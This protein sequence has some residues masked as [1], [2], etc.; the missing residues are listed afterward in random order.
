MVGK[1]RIK[2]P[3]AFIILCMFFVQIADP[4]I[5]GSAADGIY[6]YGDT[7]RGNVIT[8]EDKDRGNDRWSAD[9]S[10]VLEEGTLWWVQNHNPLQLTS[11]SF[12]SGNRE[13]LNIPGE[14]SESPLS[15]TSSE[16]TE[17]VYYRTVGMRFTIE[18]IS[19]G[20]ENV[21][22]LGM[23][24]NS[25]V[26]DDP[27]VRFVDVF[28]DGVSGDVRN[29]TSKLLAAGATAGG[30]R[31]VCNETMVNRDIT[32]GSGVIEGHYHIGNFLKRDEKHSITDD[33][34]VGRLIKL[35]CGSDTLPMGEW[36]IYA[37]HIIEIMTA[38]REKLPD[39]R[40][41]LSNRRERLVSDGSGNPVPDVCTTLVD[42]LLAAGWASVTRD[43]YLPALFNRY[44]E[45]TGE[46]L[47]RT[48]TLV[49]YYIYGTD[50]QAGLAGSRRITD[51][52]AGGSAVLLYESEEGK[53]HENLRLALNAS[54]FSNGAGGVYDAYDGI[55]VFSGNHEKAYAPEG[56]EE[57]VHAYRTR[58]ALS[59]T[60]DRPCVTPLD[61]VSESVPAGVTA[62]YVCIWAP[63][64]PAVR[65]T[66]MYVTG[67]DKKPVLVRDAGL[68]NIASSGVVSLMAPGG[69]INGSDTQAMLCDPART[70]DGA[71]Y[72][73]TNGRIRC[74]Y[75]TDRW[76]ILRD[77][78]V[79]A[80][81]S[82]GSANRTIT[83]LLLTGEET[84]GRRFGVMGEGTGGNAVFDYDRH[85]TDV[86]FFVPV[87]KTQPSVTVR[88]LYVRYVPADGEARIIKDIG[89]IVIPSAQNYVYVHEP[90]EHVT[91]NGKNYEP[92]TLRE[93]IQRP[94]LGVI[95]T[96]ADK[97]PRSYGTVV[98]Q[99]GYSNVQLGLRPDGKV[100]F[101]V[102]A[103]ARDAMLFIP[104]EEKE[105]VTLGR[106]VNIYYIKGAKEG[107]YKVLAT[108]KRTVPAEAFEAAYGNGLSGYDLAVRT[109]VTEVAT[110]VHWKALSEPG[111][112]DYAYTVV[113]NEKQGV[114]L[115]DLRYPGPRDEEEWKTELFSREIF[116]DCVSIGIMLSKGAG[117]YEVFVPC[118]IRTGNNPVVIYAFDAS[119]GR[120]LKNDP[121]STTY[122]SGAEG[123]IDVSWCE[124]MTFGEKTYVMVGES[125]EEEKIY[126]FGTVS[127]AIRDII[128]GI[129]PTMQTSSPYIVNPVCRLF[130]GV[131]G[132]KGEDG[133]RTRNVYLN[134]S[135]LGIPSGNT[136]AV[137]VPFRTSS[138]VNVYLLT[139]DKTHISPK[140]AAVV[141]E[142]HHVSRSY[143]SVESSVL[144]QKDNETAGEGGWFRFEVPDEI[145]D[146]N[147]ISY[148]IADDDPVAIHHDSCCDGVLQRVG[149]CGVLCPLCKGTGLMSVKGR[150]GASGAKEK[151]T[152]CDGSG[153]YV[154]AMNYDELSYA[155]AL[156]R[157]VTEVKYCCGTCLGTGR[158]PG[159]DMHS[160]EKKNCPEC[161]RSG[162]G[163][164]KICPACGG[165]KKIQY[166]DWESRTFMNGDG[167]YGTQVVPV[168]K[169]R[170]CAFCD[171]SGGYTCKTC[172]GSGL[173]DADLCERCQVVRFFEKSGS[174]YGSV[175]SYGS[176]YTVRNRGICENC[177]GKGFS[178]CP[179]CK[180]SGWL[181][182]QDETG[183]SVPCTACGGVRYRKEAE[184]G[185]SG[186]TLYLIT[187]AHYEYRKGSGEIKC[188]CT[189]KSYITDPA[190]GDGA[191][192][193]GSWSGYY[194]DSGDYVETRENTGFMCGG[195]YC[196]ECDTYIFSAGFPSGGTLVFGKDPEGRYALTVYNSVPQSSYD[197][198]VICDNAYR[199]VRV[200]EEPYG[201]VENHSECGRSLLYTPASYDMAVADTEN[202]TFVGRK[203]E[204]PVPTAGGGMNIGFEVYIPNDSGNKATDVYILY[205]EWK[206]D[207]M[208]GPEERI[209][210]PD[211]YERQPDI[212][213]TD[214]DTDCCEISLIAG[215]NTV[216]YDASLSIPSGRNVRLKA[217]GKEYLY[218]IR[219]VNITGMA[220]IPVT[221]RYPYAFYGSAGEARL[222]E[223]PKETGY[224]ERTVTV[225]R[226]YAYWSIEKFAVWSIDEAWAYCNALSE[227]DAG[228]V[229]ITAAAS[230][231]SK[232]GFTALR[233]GPVQ[234]RLVGC[235]QGENLVITV[236]GLYK[237]IYRNG[238]APGVPELDEGYAER[239]AYEA[240]PDIKALND[241][242]IFEGTEVIG[243]SQSGFS[244]PQ[245][246]GPPASYADVA[247]RPKDGGTVT[248]FSADRKIPVLKKNG[249]Y[250][251]YAAT[252]NYRLMPGSVGSCDETKYRSVKNPAPV[253]VQTPV[254]VKGE[255]SM[256]TGADNNIGYV[257]REGADTTQIWAVLGEERSY[258]GYDIN[259]AA[260]TFCT[261]DLY[262]K[263]TNRA[264]ESHPHLPYPGY[265]VR[266]FD[267]DIYK[268]EGEELPYNRISFDI[269]VVIDRSPGIGKASWEPDHTEN[270]AD[271]IVEAGEWISI[272]ADTTV[273]FIVPLDTPEGRHRITFAS[274]ATNKE[275]PGEPLSSAMQTANTY[276]LSHAAYDRLFF[277]V[278]GRVWGLKAEIPELPLFSTERNETHGPEIIGVGKKSAAGLLLDDP[279]QKNFPAGEKENAVPGVTV[280]FTLISSGVKAGR[281]IIKNLGSAQETGM[282]LK[283][284]PEF[285]FVPLD[286]L[287]GKI[288]RD[289]AV[290]ADLWYDPGP[291]T[292]R[293]GLV[294]FL[295]QIV[296]AYPE[297]FLGQGEEKFGFDLFIPATLKLTEKGSMNSL[298]PGLGLTANSEKWLKNGMLVINLTIEETYRIAG[299]PVKVGYD[300]GPADMWS[301][302]GYDTGGGYRKG[303]VL[304]M[305]LDV[306]IRDR[307]FV[308]HLN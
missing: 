224:S 273:R 251:V 274:V 42:V 209:R 292:G 36:R 264:D 169:Y 96:I 4:V 307:Y 235:P 299:D 287:T 242:L 66:F 278:V 1:N 123:L 63:L 146:I 213:F 181:N 14:K 285:L 308:D 135:G 69:M 159:Q 166:T 193:R 175:V 142:I 111:S 6:R 10:V 5:P 23:D 177:G 234:D 155:D 216:T 297:T 115:G 227:D 11:L 48:T 282:G 260:N 76:D 87:E 281:E 152:F 136:V 46:N 92:A 182:A 75:G 130:D 160:H 197:P 190:G 94:P 72:K 167:T 239:I 153:I 90:V 218:D 129:V 233:R 37:S 246:N 45:L 187:A 184:W 107:N 164:L 24:E 290:P 16:T 165:N 279:P 277:N 47:V 99:D 221:V 12:G 170:D 122:I 148:S 304:S 83:S 219:L 156:K 269:R 137:Y 258:V 73:V 34:V 185:I 176:G 93:G 40:Y 56:R 229:R 261:C 294:R 44:L 33:C 112:G 266:T 257:Q 293:Q 222:G 78:P 168:I 106:D 265:G 61:I 244:A 205:T 189:Q 13:S 22:T 250:P 228:Y 306:D 103:G 29:A 20:E 236:D 81:N 237:D 119:T 240:V 124:E 95:T 64:R 174:S 70:V 283:V 198:G 126:P 231:I 133:F 192:S 117:T 58:F 31:I 275:D 2:R 210:P 212:V 80:E 15:Y 267:E 173:V 97:L 110:G 144:R 131:V 254:Y 291:F 263:L 179:S 223:T 108:E 259:A 113:S 82:I 178:L 65:V 195:L 256:G 60:A 225:M 51:A 21:V 59:G 268:P 25:K 202:R 55:F 226:P 128:S 62:P 26:W 241:V 301:L 215:N 50:P 302:E 41:V 180:G 84:D 295:P 203:N 143:W 199:T 102:P 200:V 163:P 109:D 19:K 253:V 57:D 191:Y 204:A 68:Y 71:E 280:H 104:Y 194:N 298:P 303:D 49:N 186:Q 245:T 91:Y 120:L 249:T 247:N 98:S 30:R 28:L 88:R 79:S 211:P 116:S 220:E 262:A 238:A 145:C 147:G 154:T 271:I 217:K 276:Y 288:L 9:R 158:D 206:P 208:P 188:S 196:A 8:R 67:E 132:T 86:V 139:D 243:G 149:M 38:T 89:P 77:A 230:D 105:I 157:Q 161:N 100:V 125:L 121:L 151:C 85:I 172:D 286:P 35:E 252:V 138:Q 17:Y 32:N 214:I 272:P 27:S 140:E 171:G 296:Y 39:G 201:S 134:I 101:T 54:A 7:I 118:E 52:S 18:D 114:T 300:C 207:P 127:Y 53:R 248:L 232:P 305:P 43:E 162:M 255:L 270:S 289:K 74:F 183:H 150:K 3:I 141:H 284:T